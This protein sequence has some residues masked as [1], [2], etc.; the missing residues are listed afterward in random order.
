MVQKHIN[1]PSILKKKRLIVGIH[2][3]VVV[4]FYSL[5][6]KTLLV[7]GAGTHDVPLRTSA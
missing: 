5:P 6:R 1:F 7:D 2:S 3:F 4:H